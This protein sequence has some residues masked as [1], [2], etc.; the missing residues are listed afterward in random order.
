M[1]RYR[2]AARKAAEM[3]NKEL[4]T[5]IAALSPVSRD[6][7]QKLLPRKRDKEAFLELM[8]KVEE[9]TAMEEKLAYLRDNLESAGKVALTVL[10]TLL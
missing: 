6:R 8:Q 7:I 9:E 4:G 2:T 5:E 3:T 10:K 1:G